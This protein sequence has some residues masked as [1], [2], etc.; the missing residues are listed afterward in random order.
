M[1]E[2][3]I[4]YELNLDTDPGIGDEFEPWLRKHTSAMLELSGFRLAT[5]Y[6][7]ESADD[8]EH[9]HYSVHF[10]LESHAAL[11]QS[12]SEHAAETRR[13]GQERFGEQLTIH[14]RVLTESDA[15][16]PHAPDMYC[17][18][19]SSPIR[20]QYCAGCGQR[21]ISRVI[22][23]WE[24][25][26]DMVG[27][28]ADLD[29]RIWR[30][31][32][33]LLLKPGHLTADYLQGRRARYMPPFRMYLVLS[34]LFFLLMSVFHDSG[35]FI[36]DGVIS[37]DS[38][39]KLDQAQLDQARETLAEVIPEH[40]DNPELAKKLAEIR[41][42]LPQSVS[43][44]ETVPSVESNENDDRSV[45]EKCNDANIDIGDDFMPWISEEEA[46]AKARQICRKVVGDRGRSLLKGLQENFPTMLFIFLPVIALVLK[47]LYPLSRR[48][49]VEHLLFV[50]HFHAFVF[51]A[52]I[53]ELLIFELAATIQF[54]TWPFTTVLSLYIP[55]Y[56]Y[57]S[58]RRVY[59][60]S[61]AATLYK[62]VLLLFFYFFS[63]L[64]TF[65]AALVF[66][67]F[68]L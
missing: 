47:G 13:V 20:G 17:R 54:P 41:D 59:G 64:L 21:S 18:N 44:G 61:R 36:D 67:A 35:T 49:Y 5:L 22:T 65:L 56:L 26:R 63:L 24:L 52:L 39:E 51:L 9:R 66:T 62:Y 14:H 10:L 12:V 55:Y 53:L 42:S 25:T 48:Y 11:E 43:D 3:N 33:P 1:S 29:S 68:T 19:C 16:S 28:I 7:V 60:Q 23:M 37:V 40:A 27:D 4:I 15:L 6:S 58:M 2:P 45:E 31:L 46:E 32:I 8:T 34:I 30:S 50:I 57:R 38:E